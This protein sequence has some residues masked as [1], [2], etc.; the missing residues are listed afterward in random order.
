[1]IGL[2][3]VARVLQT[4]ALPAPRLIDG[5]E[6]VDGWT[7]HPADGVTMRLGSGPGK[8]G[9]ALRLD[10]AFTGGGYAIAHRGLA[11]A[12]PSNYAFSFWLRGEAKPNTLE[13]KLLDAGGENVWWYTERDRVF[14]GA[15][16]K[17]TIRRRQI[18]FAWGPQGG[19]SISRVAAIELV[20]TAGAG[21]GRGTLW[22][23]ELTLATLPEIT[24]YVLSPRVRASRFV[25]EYPADAALDGDTTTA[26]RA[27]RPTATLT[28]DFLQSREFGGLSLL[29]EPRRK[30][31]RY[32]V[33][34]SD[35]GVRW[36]AVELR[37]S[38]PDP[39][40]Y[41]FLPETQSRYLRLDLLRDDGLG[42][43]LRE[44]RIEPLEWSASR[45]AF[46]TAIA[47]E[48]PRGSYPRYLLGERAQW[49]VIGVDRAGEE[50]LLNE[51]GALE[52]GAGDFSLEPF[53]ALPGRLLSWNEGNGV[54]S[55]ARGRLPIPS[56]QWRAGP[57]SFSVTAFAIGP[58]NGSSVVAQ[59]RVR[60]TGTA[61]LSAVLYLALRPFQVNPPWQFLG[62]PGGTTRIDSLAW[63]GHRLLVNGARRVVPLDPPRGFGAAPFAGGD[64][65][66][67]LR[68]HGLPT[69]TS[70]RDRFG[71]A[72][73][74]LAWP[75]S[76]AVGDSA[77]VAVELPLV[78]GREALLAS[79][80]PR[81]TDSALRVALDRWSARIDRGTIRL[82]AAGSRLA[83]TIVTVLG[84]ILINRDGPAI[85]PGSRAYQRSWIR[86]G[87]LTS[88]ALLRFG[89]PD[90]V[91]DFLRW[92]AGYQYPD[93]K[94]PCCVDRRGA[95]PVP[96]H[97]SHG[98]LIYLAAEY[99]R[100]TGDRA[101]LAEL[102]P[103]IARA[104]G[105]LDSLRR[106]HR[107]A[108]Y[109]QGGQRDFFG[110]LPPSIS[111]EGYSAK[112]MHSYWDD[113]FALRGFKDAAAAAEVLGKTQESRRWA[114]TAAEFAHDLY[115]S[116]RASM[117]RHQIDFIPGAADLGD[118][119]ATSTTIAVSPGGELRRLPRE[120]LERT[121]ERYWSEVQARQAPGAQWD[122]Y[123]PYELRTVGTL[124]RLG[125]KE[126]ALQLLEG[127]LRDQEPPAW[128]Q[129][130]E[131]VWHDPH[132]PKFIGDLPHTW[133]GSD[134]L[135]SAA[136]LFAYEQEEDSTLVVG[137][138]IADAWLG[139]DGVAVR[140]LSTWWGPLS[141]HASRA[142]EGRIVAL[143]RGVR[144]PAGGLLVYPPGDGAARTVLLDGRAVPADSAGA[145]RVRSLPAR[146]VFA[147]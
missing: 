123:T 95:D 47:R 71:A 69:A 88:T 14:D 22:F 48:A 89:Y 119:D 46:F 8:Q 145:V 133:V 124:L 97:D 128:N 60:N 135:R 62:T 108:A 31:A 74:A 92:F 93:G 142:A 125:H 66:G 143:E 49:T 120:A 82:P 2:L 29:W 122:A 136:D 131:V 129:W 28:V 117:E 3:L 141:Y 139:G 111:H 13:F 44:L 96:E 114:E 110:L 118:F 76:L 55:L 104:A 99:Y 147:P 42:F 65:V 33:S 20:I 45:N 101:L 72:S 24:P 1:M 4:T 79:R 87:A 9:K 144:V 38:G 40:D 18:G 19:G 37:Q 43:G 116:I 23:D 68:R 10:F 91:R 16:H 121:F 112:P 41:L 39:H 115:A 64:V 90:E 21:G 36:Q 127:F 105:Y 5:F 50:A 56:V 100:H 67:F 106:T 70:V 140:G 109:S 15:W 34:V 134:F 85:Q 98:E 107:T 73:G 126:R 57:V 103:H 11:L 54:V 30:A 27:P 58:E 78:R 17:V 52:A 84:H 51:D 12:L 137:A 138:G 86:D 59:Y 7:P 102:W 32:Q 146:I 75:L 81:A 132:A 35:D 94:V 53:L 61:P 80:G 63:D 25:P 6:R 113:F 130:P 77:T 83:Q 26:W